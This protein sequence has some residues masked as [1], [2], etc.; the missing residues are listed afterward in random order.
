M[1]VLLINPF[2][3]PHCQN[4]EILHGLDLGSRKEGAFGD[5]SLALLAY[6]TKERRLQYA[7]RKS[8]FS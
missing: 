1:L 2:A 8:P 3:A 6:H 7:S 5:A 4:E